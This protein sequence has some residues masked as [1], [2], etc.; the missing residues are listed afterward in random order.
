MEYA[1]RWSPEHANHSAPFLTAPESGVHRPDGVLPGGEAPRG[2]GVGIGVL[3]E[4]MFF[5]R[6]FWVI[7]T[8][9]Q[10]FESVQLVLKS[11]EFRLLDTQ[12]FFRLD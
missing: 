11:A 6:L 1:T 2:T 3:F 10:F 5:L 4:P 7:E 12:L 8:L 9:Q